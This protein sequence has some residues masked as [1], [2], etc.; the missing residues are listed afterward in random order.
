[1]A[2][3]NYFQNV[4]A[5]KE[6]L[7]EFN[8]EP[9]YDYS[10][11]PLAQSYEEFYNFCMDNLEIAKGNFDIGV[12]FLY[13]STVRSMNAGAKKTP[14]GISIIKV[15][16]TIIEA[17]DYHF[18]ESDYFRTAG[19]KYEPLEK[20]CGLPLSKLMLQYCTLFTYYHE[21]AHLIQDS[22]L[23]SNFTSEEVNVNIPYSEEKHL[24]E[25]DADWFAAHNIAEHLI[26]FFSR[27]DESPETALDINLKK[28]LVVISLAGIYHYFNL[29][30]SASSG[31][32]F[33]SGTHPHFS[34][35]LL[36]VNVLITNHLYKSLDEPFRI[37]LKSS[38]Q[39]S[40]DLLNSLG[41]SSH[42]PWL[43]VIK[44]N[45]DA[46]N[47]YI[48]EMSSLMENKTN[49]ASYKLEQLGRVKKI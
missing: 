7:P 12:T 13:Y 35:R 5:L 42:T 30:S 43:E 6:R 29:F 32:Y 26:D 33:K 41:L 34:I 16:N 9:I 31:I 25:I 24:L 18:H 4:Q 39:I 1:M 11:D 40:S 3:A 22:P 27:L 36:M 38:I 2:I 44:L 8:N 14:D 10:E 23:N 21:L 17:L 49:L 45:E 28:E 15:N 20:K 19:L 48:S 47:N 37:D 46:I